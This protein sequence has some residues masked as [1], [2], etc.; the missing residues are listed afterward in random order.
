[1]SET[2]GSDTEEQVKEEEGTEGVEEA[3]MEE[4]KEDEV[5]AA[6]TSK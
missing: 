2:V 3:E 1:M 4:G 5:A 6:E